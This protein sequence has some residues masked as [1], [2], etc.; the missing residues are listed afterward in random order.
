MRAVDAAYLLITAL[1]TI[2]SSSVRFAAK[3]YVPPM[4]I[5]VFS[6]IRRHQR[7]RQMTDSLWFSSNILLYL[8]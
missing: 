2:T 1:Y 7:T 3:R 6:V 4:A 8:A 5:S